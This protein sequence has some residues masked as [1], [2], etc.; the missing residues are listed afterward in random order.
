MSAD[1]ATAE[2][3][4][5]SFDLVSGKEL[6]RKSFPSQEHKLHARSSYASCT[7]CAN[8][9]AVYFAW[10]TPESLTVK[11]FTHDGDELWGKDFG[12]YVSAHGFGGSPILVDDKV[13]LANSQDAEE[14]PAAFSL[15]IALFL[16]SMPRV[17]KRSGKRLAS[18]FG[19]VMVRRASR[20]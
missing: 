13:I 14:L 2:R 10:A 11:A 3:Y 20:W 7:P 8:E 5:L 6:W 18:R 15:A 1:S 4:A 19:P 12:R 9:R 17:A 16:P